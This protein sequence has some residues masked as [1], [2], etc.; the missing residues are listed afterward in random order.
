VAP[1]P[2]VAPPPGIAPAKA[3]VELHGDGSAVVGATP[4]AFDGQAEGLAWPALRKAV[5]AKTGE[6]VV[7]AI[8]RDVPMTAVLRAAWALRD[9]DLRLQ[10]PDAVGV[11]RVI[12]LLPKPAAASPGCHLA[13]FLTEAGSLRIAAPG[14]PRAIGGDAPADSLARALADERTRCPIRYVAFGAEP[15][16]ATW[17]S[18]FDLAWAVERDRSAGDARVVLATPIRSAPAA[19]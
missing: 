9:A 1:S 12:E 15:P 8:G 13:V 16:K 7:M 3:D 6:P 14:G 18:V 19:K 17:G 10:T 11:T 5:T 4:V 2:V